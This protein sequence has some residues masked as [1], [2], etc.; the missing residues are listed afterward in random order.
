MTIHSKLL[1]LSLLFAST[2]FSQK[3]ANNLLLTDHMDITP[4]KKNTI[5]YVDQLTE[6]VLTEIGAEQASRFDSTYF[7]DTEKF[8]VLSAS[9]TKPPN[10]IIVIPTSDYTIKKSAASQEAPGFTNSLILSIQFPQLNP[11]ETVRVKTKNIETLKNKTNFTPTFMPDP[12]NPTKLLSIKFH[13][14]NAFKLFWAKSKDFNLEQNRTLLTATLQHHEA[15]VPEVDMVDSSDVLPYLELSAI[16]TWSE[17]GNA[18]W[19]TYKPI[20]KV[21]PKIQEMADRIAG[22]S[23][24]LEAAK[25]LYQWEINNIHYIAIYLNQSA[26]MVPNSAQTILQRGYGDCK[27]YVTLLSDLLI[28]KG[29]QAQPAMVNWSYAFREYPIPSS[30]QFNHAILYLPQ[31]KLFLNPTDIHSGFGELDNALTDTPAMVVGEKSFMTKTQASHAANN[32]VNFKSDTMLT[33]TGNLEGQTSATYLG[34]YNTVIRSVVTTV[35]SGSELA[36][37]ILSNSYYGGQGR[38]RWSDPKKILQNMTVTS[39]WFSAQAIKMNNPIYMRMPNGPMIFD[40]DH[41][42]SSLTMTKRHYPMVAGRRTL[43]IEQSLNLPKNYQFKLIPNNLHIENSI[44]SY[45][46]SYKV[47][48]KTLHKTVKFIIKKNIISAKAYPLYLKLMETAL[49]DQH[50]FISVVPA[51]FLNK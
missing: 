41:L 11:K 12:N 6:E 21:T 51:G 26:Q 45:D 24:G 15:I 43:N 29:I 47:V 4:L 14:T 50:A 40:I 44:G 34:N 23:T 19:Q 9:V 42:K 33:K 49:E 7:P 22:Q 16:K 35:T 25:K 31:Y 39:H 3:A 20:Y 38:M 13:N 36:D 1:C 17:F 37:N 8:N 46:A 30:L 28:A 10:K 5:Q 32:G 48:E 27:D 2:I 18:M